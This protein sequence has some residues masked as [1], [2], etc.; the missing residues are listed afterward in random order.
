VG[1]PG[2][3]RLA[4]PDGRQPVDKEERAARLGRAVE[5][6]VKLSPVCDEDDFLSRRIPA[7]RNEPRFAARESEG[8]G[9][10]EGR[11][12]EAGAARDDDDVGATVRAGG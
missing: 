5:I 8:K 2:Q 9:E 10:T 7:E 11:P 6:G 4:P 1:E 3:V 12:E